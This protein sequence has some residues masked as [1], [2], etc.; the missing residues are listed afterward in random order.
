MGEEE[1]PTTSQSPPRRNEPRAYTDPAAPASVLRPNDDPQSPD[2]TDDRLVSARVARPRAVMDVASDRP[3]AI[4]RLI[5]SCVALL[6]AIVNG[7]ASLSG[8][9]DSVAVA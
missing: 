5:A 4:A 6:H 9:E 3:C 8:P 1:D 7:G 2:V